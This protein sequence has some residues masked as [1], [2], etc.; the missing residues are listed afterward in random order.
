MRT[1]NAAM[2]L[3]LLALGFVWG[4]SFILMKLALFDR[5]G[6]PLFSALDVAMGRIAIAGLA[7]LPIAVY[8]RQYLNAATLPWL[9]VVGTVGNLVPAYCFTTAQ[10]MIP[11]SVA[12]MLNALTPMFTFLVGV[13]L[14]GTR[15]KRLQV[16]GLLV[17]LLGA[18]VLAFQPGMG[19]ALHL[20]MASGAG[21]VVL[22]TACYGLS[23]NVIRHKLGHV[24]APAVAAL[25]LGMVGLPAMGMALA[26][27]SLGLAFDHPDGMRG[28]AAVVVL[29]VVGTGL[30]LVAFNRIIQKTNALF[31]STVTYIIPLFATM[32]GWLDD[33]PLTVLHLLGGMVVLVGVRL[34]SLGGKS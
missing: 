30:A 24:P 33:E 14:F 13:V 17:G 6:M 9:L 27:P 19:S 29:A 15:M 25:S 31:A 20:D 3:A 7:M 34:V 12:G 28:L 10:T 26:G 22:A 16:A 21:R 11:S 32:W 2:W 1:S 5:G 23:V 18:G 4:S 8:H